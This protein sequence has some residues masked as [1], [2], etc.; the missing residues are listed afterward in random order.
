MVMISFR[1]LEEK[2]LEFLNEVRNYC[3]EE[4]LHDS[5]TFS[6]NDT[7]NWF[8]TT[9]PNYYV[10]LNED[11]K[12]GYFRLSNYSIVNRNIYIGAD[13]HPNFWGKKLAYPSYKNFIDYLFV[14]YNLNKI[15]LEVL[16]TN[17]R[18]YNLYKKLGFVQEGIKR[19][20]ILKQDKFVDS[21]IMSLL[22]TE[23]DAHILE[24]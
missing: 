20:E 15:S 24:N 1:R 11:E 10:I 2:D 17:V 21:I 19:Q 18:A 14:N 13:L 23:Y 16:S 12:I 8:K 6:L 22:K 4:Y 9:H 7:L 3:A 5:R